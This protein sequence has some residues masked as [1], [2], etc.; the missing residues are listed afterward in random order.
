MSSSPTFVGRQKNSERNLSRAVPMTALGVTAPAQ[1]RHVSV[2]GLQALARLGFAPQM[3]PESLRKS[4]LQT[5]NELPPSWRPTASPLMS[6]GTVGASARSRSGVTSVVGSGPYA[7][8]AF[9]LLLNTGRESQTIISSRT[10]SR[11]GG[12]WVDNRAIPRSANPSPDTPPAPMSL[13]SAHGVTP[14]RHSSRTSR[15]ARANRV[16]ALVVR[17]QFPPRRLA[18]DPPRRILNPARGAPGVQRAY[19]CAFLS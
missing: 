10:S 7:R 4:A 6:T 19:V 15:K 1:S 3:S 17:R 5:S 16:S 12:P 2:R 14:S 13:A 8:P 11:C 9:A 18:R